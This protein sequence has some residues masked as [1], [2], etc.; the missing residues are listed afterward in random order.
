MTELCGRLDGGND[1]LVEG[2]FPECAIVWAGK[3]LKRESPPIPAFR[4]RGR[5]RSRGA[6]SQETSLAGAGGLRGLRG[7]GFCWRACFDPPLEVVPTRNPITCNKRAADPVHPDLAGKKCDA[8][9]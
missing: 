1:W 7:R 4:W 8:N 6:V 2:P 9:P 3:Q 5:G